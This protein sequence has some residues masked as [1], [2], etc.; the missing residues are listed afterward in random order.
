MAKV[1]YTEV[2]TASALNRVGG[3]GFKWSLN[4][5]QGC[6]HDCHYCFARHYNYIRD[7]DPDDQ[8]SRDIQV[9]VNIARALRK[10]LSRSSW[11]RETVAVG[12]A[13]DPYQPIEG[14]YRLTRSCLEAFCLKQ[15]PIS[16][17]TKGTMV[18]RDVDLL[19]ELSQSAGC[20]VCI[21]MTTLDDDLWHRL[22]PGTPPPRQ[23]LRAMERLATEG[24]RV[25][26]ILAPIIPGIT[27]G[28]ANLRDVV[29]GAAQHGACFLDG[30]VLFLKD[31]TKQH[32]MDFLEREYPSLVSSY[33]TL[34]PGIFAPW[35]MKKSFQTKIDQLKRA[36]GLHERYVNQATPQRIGQLQL[37]L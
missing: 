4:P 23:R 2:E 11:K 21:S 5:Y 7:L 18:V 10:E 16:L 15:T 12:T 20:T 19:S 35:Q 14:K 25:G 6:P 1:N 17:V 32:F 8:F 34:Y 22:E 24:V 27:D 9:K 36:Y 31:G 3:M 28:E 26:V 33:K 30:N 37:A 13:T 29:R